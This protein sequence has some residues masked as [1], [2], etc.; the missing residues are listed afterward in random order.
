MGGE[1]FFLVNREKKCG[2]LAG[3]WAGGRNR[4]SLPPRAGPRL[5]NHGGPWAPV[6][7]KPC[8]GEQD[9]KVPGISSHDCACMVTSHGNEGHCYDDTPVPPGSRAEGVVW[10]GLGGLTPAGAPIGY[11]LSKHGARASH[12][13]MRYKTKDIGDEGL[14]IDR[15]SDRG[16][17]Q[18]R[19]PRRGCAIAEGASF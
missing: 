4:V 6:Q 18:G 2:P 13:P 15:G 11:A 16:L 12:L 9:W 3:N 10:E 5:R 17:A 19:V 1:W 8:E 14:D 7:R